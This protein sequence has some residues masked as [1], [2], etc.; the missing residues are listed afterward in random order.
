MAKHRTN[1]NQMPMWGGF[2]SSQVAWRP[3]PVSSL[4]SWA[5]AK[6][7]AVDLETVRPPAT[8]AGPRGAAGRADRRHL[9]RHRGR[10]SGTT[11][12]IGH[13]EDNLDPDHVFGYL[14]DQAKVFDGDIVGANLQYDLDFLW[15][16]NVRFPKVKRYR[17]I[18]IAD[19]LINELHESYSMH[20]IALR[21]GLPGKDESSCGAG[22]RRT[23]STRRRACGSCPPASSASTP[24]RTCGCRW[25]SPP[26]G[27]GDRQPEPVGHL[28]PG[29]RLL[30]VLVKM[31]RRGVAV[32][33]AH[34]QK[35]E[36]WTLEQQQLELKK[37]RQPPAS[38]SAWRT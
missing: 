19:P 29:D 21:L 11:S 25:P 37:I 35:V 8:R 9:L 27:A 6:R 15:H 16:R 33:F 12:P 24:S 26:T 38:G 10:A 36:D 32:D 18:Q 1:A 14:R 2:A 17:D 20:N 34:L 30:P 22:R 13:A 5:G 31:R 23:T 28:R 7:V 4:P 3:A